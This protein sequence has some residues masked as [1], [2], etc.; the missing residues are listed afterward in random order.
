MPSNL[1]FWK[2]KDI[3]RLRGLG[4]KR[5][6]LLNSK[7][8]DPTGDYVLYWMQMTQRTTFNFA[9]QFAIE[10]ANRYKV[11]LVVY[12]ALDEDYPYASDRTYTFI[13]QGVK[14]LYQRFKKMGINYGFYLVHGKKKPALSNLMKKAVCV[15][16]DDYP[17]F[18]TKHFN[19]HA[20]ASCP[21]HYIVVDS[22]TVVS[23]RFFE[24][25]EWSAASIRPKIKKV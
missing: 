2:T 14:E 16:S 22:C 19:D 25:Q 8:D 1:P 11:P 6:F 24:K 5:I 18:V 12:H 17:T 3:Q 4:Q 21:V 7:Q 23:M 10:Q 9:L 20:A 15:V 13:L